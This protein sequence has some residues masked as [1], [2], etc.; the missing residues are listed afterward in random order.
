MQ[1]IKAIKTPFLAT[2]HIL[3]MGLFFISGFV[4]PL[5]AVVIIAIVI[6]A[7]LEIF[8]G[9]FV[10]IFQQK[11]GALPKDTEFIPFLAEKLFFGKK[12][13][14][15]QQVL[16]SFILFQFPLVIAVVKSF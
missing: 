3:L 1:I 4:L 5:R 9:C 14:I 8:G 10:T 2:L 13:S 6:Q 7:S 12:L 15:N 11:V 16:V